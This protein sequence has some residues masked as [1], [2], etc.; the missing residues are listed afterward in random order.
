MDERPHGGA[1]SLPSG[2]EALQGREEAAPFPISAT[3]TPPTP[4]GEGSGLES[5]TA[6]VRPEPGL[7]TAA[8]PGT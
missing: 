3:I 8:L 1:K 4:L 7:L 5:R 2:V 6:W